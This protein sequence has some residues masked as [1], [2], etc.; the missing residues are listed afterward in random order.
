MLKNSTLVYLGL[1]FSLYMVFIATYEFSGSTIK[2]HFLM[3]SPLRIAWS[4]LESGL[5][6]I[7]GIYFV[8]V[9]AGWG[10]ASVWSWIYLKGVT[11]EVPGINYSLNRITCSIMISYL[12]IILFSLLGYALGLLLRHMAITVGV[13]L[14]LHLLIPSLGKYDYKNLI[15]TVYKSAYQLEQG[16]AMNYY[17]GVS[18]VTALLI[19]FAYICGIVLFAY[20]RFYRN[21]KQGQNW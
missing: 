7:T 21:W 11:V 14:V 17:P 9:L 10:I 12:V 5:L 20:L 2:T 15:I 13:T 8:A 3:E 16:I 4:K 18:V 6:I 1:L 19:L